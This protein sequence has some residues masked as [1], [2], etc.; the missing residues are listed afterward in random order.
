M[1]HPDKLCVAMLINFKQ[2]YGVS[3]PWK[4]QY[5]HTSLVV[6]SSPGNLLV[7]VGLQQQHLQGFLWYYFFLFFLSVF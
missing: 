1:P 6:M 4:I 2:Y 7:R 5:C 3:K